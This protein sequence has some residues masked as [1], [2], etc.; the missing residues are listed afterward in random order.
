MF[1]PE[2]ISTA[3]VGIVGLRQPFDPEFAILDAANILSASG[4]WVT[5]NAYA[6]ISY[7]KDTQD[8]EDISNADFNTMLRNMQKASIVNVCSQVFKDAD[9]IDRN[10]IYKYAG[11]KAETDILPE[12]FVGRRIIVSDEKNVAFK[13]TRVLLDFAGLGSFTLMLFN[14][15]QLTPLYTKEI[16]ITTDHQVEVLDWTVDNSGNTYKGEYYIG[17]VVPGLSV[18]Q[19]YKRDYEKA[20]VMN[21]ITYLEI[22]KIHV[23]NYTGTELFDVRTVQ[24]LNEADGLNFDITVYEDFTDLIINNKLLFARAIYLDFIISFLSVYAATSRSTRNQF[25]TESII[26]RAILEVEGSKGMQGMPPIKGLRPQLI[27]EISQ[28]AVELDKI[29]KGYFGE[30]VMV[31][32]QC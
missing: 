4:L 19:P 25:L 1:S 3:L 27:R 30:E 17:Y 31:I 28:I 26:S 10:L 13:I 11:S 8:Y 7:L 12:G 24:Y 9:Y 16:T 20:M 21:Y 22:D 23:Q 2:K 6:K 14:T 18:I 32:T 15:A 5:D 29:R